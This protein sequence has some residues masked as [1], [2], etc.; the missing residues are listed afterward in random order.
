MIQDDV[1]ACTGGLDLTTPVVALPKGSVQAC[2]NWEPTATSDGYRE[3]DGYER[4]DGQAL[5]S[6][7]ENPATQRALINP[8]PGSGD[9]RGVWVFDD[10]VYAFRD[11][12]GATEGKMYKATGSGWSEVDLGATLSFTTGTAEFLVGETVTG[13][14][15]GATGI[16]GLVVVSSG[17]WGTSNAAG[18]L[19]L[20]TVS[21]TFQSETI[22]STSGSATASGAQTAT[23]LA[24]GGKYRFI[25]ANFY[26]TAPRGCMYGV[27]GQNKAFEFDGTCFRQISTGMVDDTPDFIAAH[28]GR[29]F[30][31]FTEGSVQYSGLSDPASTFS[32]LEGAGEFG[33]GNWLTNIAPVKSEVL[34]VYGER[35]IYLL[36]GSGPSDFQLQQYS[37][38]TGA[39][40]DTLQSINDQF[41]LDVEGIRMLSATDAYGDFASTTV[42]NK[43]VPLLDTYK[44]F[45][46]GSLVVR[47][48]NQYRLYFTDNTETV[49]ITL[50]LGGR[51]PN[52]LPQRFPVLFT[53][54]AN[55]TVGGEEWILAGASNG[56]VY[57]LDSGN[58]FDGD[59]INSMIR[60]SWVH[61]KSPG[62]RKRFREVRFETSSIETRSMTF[63]YEMNYADSHYPVP[64]SD[65]LQFK[66]V[67]GI[68]GQG[69]WGDMAWGGFPRT[70]FKLTGSGTNIALILSGS[71][72]TE[73]PVEI[74]AIRLRYEPRKRY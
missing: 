70:R 47:E 15:S 10:A 2:Y 28:K 69:A 73:A 51:E 27:D 45:L 33:I 34:A 71:R 55:G 65:T 32:A 59:A 58:S 57:K 1:F 16:V 13:G 39:Y 63:G 17:D 43:I 42:S 52:Y 12:S 3:I 44:G 26:A 49:S 7:S 11:N 67:G 46:I 25:N 40:P 62:I 29:L 72:T 4:Y 5:A 53:T 22:T 14:T 35:V 9:V 56:Y 68:W 74:N 64:S 30:L 8:V 38:N 60:L 21:G 24:T 6:A 31:G 23:T 48:K 37:F 18:V 41:F 66:P 61:E 50:G 19:Y 54:F 20:H 36:Y